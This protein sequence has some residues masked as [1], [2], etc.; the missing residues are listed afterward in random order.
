MSPAARSLTARAACA[1]SSCARRQRRS[2][3]RWLA[4]A[5][6][7][8]RLRNP[9]PNEPTPRNSGCR[10]DEHARARAARTTADSLGR[11]TSPS[12]ARRFPCRRSLVAPAHHRCLPALRRARSPPTAPRSTHARASDTLGGAT[13]A[14]CNVI[15]PASP[16]PYGAAYR[17][18]GELRK[19]LG[20]RQC[21]CQSHPRRAAR[22]QAR[23]AAQRTA[24]PVTRRIPSAAAAMLSCDTTTWTRSCASSASSQRR[25]CSIRL[26]SSGTMK[27]L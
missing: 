27:L 14:R 19:G 13:R 1:W 11:L 24:E 26:V 8:S 20:L 7:L 5:S 3:A 15:L 23:S 10:W 16:C 9:R 4:P 2:P 17:R 22:T 21:Q 12:P 18:R 25:S 6:L